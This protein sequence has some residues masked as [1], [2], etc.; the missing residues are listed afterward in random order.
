MTAQTCRKPLVSAVGVS[1]HFVMS[2]S[3]LSRRLTRPL[4]QTS[5]GRGRREHGDIPW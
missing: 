2:E 4:R 5:N 1:K 3:L